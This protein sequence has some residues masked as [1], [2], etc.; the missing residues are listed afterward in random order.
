MWHGLPRPRVDGQHRENVFYASVFFICINIEYICFWT[1][2]KA[3]NGLFQRQRKIGCKWKILEY[4]NILEILEKIY[5]GLPWKKT[6]QMFL[7]IL[8]IQ[9]PKR[10]FTRTY[11]FGEEKK[12]SKYVIF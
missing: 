12:Y 8:L 9:N 3:W 4:L 6:M 5:N 7:H 10:T 1:I 2:R 11:R